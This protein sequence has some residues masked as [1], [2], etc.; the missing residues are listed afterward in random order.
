MDGDKVEV[1]RETLRELYKAWRR[2][3]EYW[4]GW[5][6]SRRSPHEAAIVKEV[7]EALGD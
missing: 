5:R 2:D 7:A 6:R 1:S 4:T 3:H